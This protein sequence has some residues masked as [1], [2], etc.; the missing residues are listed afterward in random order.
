MKFEEKHRPKTLDDIIFVDAYVERIVKK[1]AANK[2]H[3]HLILHGPRGAGKS[4]TANLIMKS[5]YAEE[6]VNIAKCSVHASALED[7]SL[8]ILTGN[9][10]YQRAFGMLN[11]CLVI[12]EVDQLKP[13]MQ[14]TLRAIVDEHTFGIIICTT[15]NLHRID[16]P[17]QD[18]CRCLEFT[19]P[20]V[21]Q[22]LPRAKAILDTNGI[23]LTEVQTQ[24]LLKGFEGSGRKMMD[25]LEDTILDFTSD[26]SEF[27]QLLEARTRS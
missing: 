5:R 26:K 25:W 12:E 24:L 15:N 27:D 23:F 21:D 22:W 13:G 8:D 2:R 14:Q 6:D 19:Y 3:K 7:K 20:T 1:T 10:N 9:W 17:L 11:G 18:R 16:Q 4:E